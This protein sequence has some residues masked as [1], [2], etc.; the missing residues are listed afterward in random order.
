[1]RSRDISEETIVAMYMNNKAVE[2]LVDGRVDDAY[3]WVREAIVQSPEYLSSHNTLGVIYMRRGDL[4]HS[5]TVFEYLL[6]REPTN[7]RAMSNLAQVMTRQGRD[8][9]AAA[10]RRRLAQ[11]RAYRTVSLFQPRSSRDGAGKLHAG[12]RVVRKGSRPRRLSG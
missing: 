9:E 5:A 2:A 7:A 8:V 4:A 10:L 11:D 6:E 3:A 1:M 12:A